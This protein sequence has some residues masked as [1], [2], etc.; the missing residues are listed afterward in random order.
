MVCGRGN[1]HTHTQFVLH[2][3]G[4]W[5]MCWQ[6]QV[7]VWLPYIHLHFECNPDSGFLGPLS[8]SFCH[9]KSPRQVGWQSTLSFFKPKLFANSTYSGLELQWIV[10]Q[11]PGSSQ[12]RRGDQGLGWEELG[13][14]GGKGRAFLGQGPVLLI[15]VPAVPETGHITWQQSLSVNMYWAPDI[16][17]GQ[18]LQ[19][20]TK[21]RRKHC[22][23]FIFCG[24]R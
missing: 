23:Q 10:G 11:T 3:I 15:L 13:C 8:L 12:I 5:F 19:R 17:Q 22:P 2:T 4:I 7:L 24:D 14:G 9:S 1:T 20:W 6:W 21:L 18:R 16:C